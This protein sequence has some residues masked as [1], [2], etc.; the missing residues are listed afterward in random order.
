MEEK[1]EMGFTHTRAVNQLFVFS[2]TQSPSPPLCPPLGKGSCLLLLSSDRPERS[3]ASSI[4]N[5]VTQQKLLAADVSIQ[6]K[7]Q[8]P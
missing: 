7:S 5:P 4:V 1:I 6:T 8:C 3:A 2:V